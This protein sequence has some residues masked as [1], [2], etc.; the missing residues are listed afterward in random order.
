MI[1]AARQL[2]G[3][4]LSAAVCIALHALFSQETENALREVSSRLV[5]TNS[6]PHP[7][8]EID[9]SGIIAERYLQFAR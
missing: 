9:L 6:V 3:E 1:E 7:S 5:T 2:R 4:G 8:N